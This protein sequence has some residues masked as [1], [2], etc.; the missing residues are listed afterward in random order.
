ML[1]FEK[2]MLPVIMTMIQLQALTAFAFIHYAHE[3]RFLLPAG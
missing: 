1:Q 2:M 3:E